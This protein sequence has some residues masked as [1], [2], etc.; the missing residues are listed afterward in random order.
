MTRTNICLTLAAFA[1]LA[2]LGPTAAVQPGGVTIKRDGN[3]IDF[4]VGDELVGRYQVGKEWARP[5]FWPLHAPGGVPVTRAWPIDKTRAGESTDHPH[6]KSVWFCWGDIIPEGMKVEHKI[7]RIEGVDFWSEA[8]GHGRIVVTGVGEP[9]VGK[10]SGSVTTKNEWRTAD[11]RKVLDETRTLRLYDFGKARLLVFDIDLHASVYP[12][13]FGDTKEGAL[14]V[15][16][17]DSMRADKVGKGKIVNAD[18]KVNEKEAWGQLSRWC[19]Y[20]GPVGGK[21]VGLTVFDDPKNPHPVVW[22]VRGYGLMAANPFGRAKARFPAVAGRTDLVR[23]AKGEHLR[24]RYGILLHAG[25]ARDANVAGYYER[26][27]KLRAMEEK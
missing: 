19:D 24:F 27:V 9:K 22:H 3:H 4:R 15:R 11:G 10:N 6:Q 13:T 23:L 26:F 14:G 16:V 7:P 20:S 1:L 18:G 17:A 5:F 2:G 21:T 12:I 25:D 8:K